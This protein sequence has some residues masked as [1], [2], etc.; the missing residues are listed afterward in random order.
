MKGSSRRSHPSK[1]AL[2]IGI[3]DYPGTGS[4]LHG[5]VND[6]ADWE[7]LLRSK[8]FD[9]ESLLDD[10]AS[11][12]AIRAGILDLAHRAEKGDV[13][14]VT[15]S[16]HGSFVPDLDGDEDD[17]NDEC[18]C[19]HDIVANG[20][21][22]DDELHE[23][24]EQRSSGVCWIVI[25]DSCHSGT[26]TRFSPITTPPTVR[27]S[28]APQR[29]VRFLPPASFIKTAEN[30][31]RSKRRRAFVRASPPGREGVLLMSGCQDTEYSYDAWFEGRANGAFTF[32][33]LRE[34]AN[35]P[36]TTTYEAW[37]EQIRETL[38]SS[39]YPQSPNIY[40]RKSM[41]RWIAFAAEG[42]THS[43]QTTPTTQITTDNGA[44]F[45]AWDVGR[46]IARDVLGRSAHRS[47]RRN[48]AP[49]KPLIAEGDSWFDYP[50]N[51]VLSCLEDDHGFDI[52]SVSHKG[53]TIEEMA[54][55]GGQLEKFVRTLEKML[56]RGD[57][58][59]AVLLSGGG[60]D[61]AGDEF[62]QLLNH[63]RSRNRGLNQAIVDAIVGERI[64]DS[65]ATII[66]AVSEV[67]IDRIGEKIPIVTHGYSYAV[68]DGRGYAGGWWVLPGPWLQPGFARK[69]Y[70]ETQEMQT[71]V[72]QL[73]DA[74]NEMQVR[75]LSSP[76]FKHVQHVDLRDAFPR[77]G[78]HK[79]W[80][81]NELHP[82]KRGFQV[83]AERFARAI[84]D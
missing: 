46:S 1:L 61:V 28:A 83:V 22:I 41:Q 67:C 8:G 12:D 51:D 14:V 43:Q 63:S 9:C 65:Y 35:L 71:I 69:G 74:L 27:G 36:E 60:N 49:R 3:N 50:W 31:V 56:D 38:P 75:M 62:A 78:N 44:I 40:G 33:A 18:W 55:S 23:I 66:S 72:D 80:W 81:A 76:G 73:I 4:D 64:R 11:G 32:V 6:A 68:P 13:V 10:A 5:C 48:R 39:Q 19:P 24:Y 47:R 84:P 2:C 52:S 70:R 53:D 17:G 30:K 7:T 15:F 20:P 25:S 59:K 37:Y 29:L 26:I 21:I 45:D 58:P 57:R 16:G 77:T 42:E 79:D 82:T 54:Y 34:L